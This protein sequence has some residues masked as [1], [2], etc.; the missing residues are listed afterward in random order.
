MDWWFDSFPVVEHDGSISWRSFL[1]LI[2]YVIIVNWWAVLTEQIQGAPSRHHRHLVSPPAVGPRFLAATAS[3]SPAV[4][5]CL[6]LPLPHHAPSQL[7][8]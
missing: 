1:F 6:A 2:T 3:S 7:P 5:A 8:P 4:P